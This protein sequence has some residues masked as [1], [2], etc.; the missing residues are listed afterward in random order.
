MTLDIFQPVTAECRKVSGGEVGPECRSE[1]ERLPRRLRNLGEQ[2][3]D[4]AGR[5]R[6]PALRGFRRRP[7]QTQELQGYQ[8]VSARAPQPSRKRLSRRGVQDVSCERG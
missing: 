4:E 2:T 1:F 7:V 5:Q 8:R 3:L 6:Q